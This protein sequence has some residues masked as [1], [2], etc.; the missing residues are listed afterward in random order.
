MSEPTSESQ[1]TTSSSPEDDTDTG[2]TTSDDM[3]ST[4]S[5]TYTSNGTLRP[6]APINYNKTLL[7]HLHRRPQIRT[8]HNVSI[9]FPDSS[10]EETQKTDEH[11]YEDTDEHTLEDTHKDTNTDVTSE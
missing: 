4:T 2:S 9:P 8:A 11:I 3:Q 5:Q 6:K 7:K 1:K 10:D